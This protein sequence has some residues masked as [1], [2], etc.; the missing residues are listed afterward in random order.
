MKL[1]TQTFLVLVLLSMSISSYSQNYDKKNDI[2]KEI[3]INKK[4]LN[5]PL[6]L[7]RNAPKSNMSIKIDGDLLGTFEMPLAQDKEDYYGFIDLSQHLGKI[8]T[9]ELD[10]FSRDLQKFTLDD[11]IKGADNLYM[12]QY[13]PQLHFTSRRGWLNDPNGLI[14]YKGE[15]HMYYQHNPLSVYWGNLSW[16]HA[17]SKDLVHWEEQP[18]VLFPKS[19]TGTCYSGATFIDHNNQ[20]GLKTGE[21]DA[22]LAFY[23][24]TKIGLCFAYSNDRGQTMTEFEGNPVLT[25]EGARI[26]TPRP[27]WFE[28]TNRWIAPTFDFFTNEDG[29]KHRCVGFYSSKNLKD[30]RFESRVEQDKGIHELCGCVDFFQLPV[31]GNTAEKKWIMIFIDGSY[32]VGTFNGRT[33]YTLTGKPASTKDRIQSLVVSGNYYATMTWHNMPN[34]RRVQ[35]TWMKTSTKSFPGMPFNQ[36]M[37]LPSE[38]TL[39]LTKDGHRLHMNPIKELEKLRTKTHR[40]NNI[41]LD[42]TNNL[43]SVLNDELYEIEVEFLPRKKSITVLDLRGVKISYNALKEEISLNEIKTQL[44]PEDGKINLQ[45]FI[46]RTSIEVYA[47]GGKV[48]MPLINTMP[49]E[50][51]NYSILAAQGESKVK[52]LKV[53]ELSSIWF[54]KESIK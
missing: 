26:D 20:L 12:E 18:V 28:P 10:S 49:Q 24:R 37:T 23:L 44:K 21:E 29:K 39:H 42:K 16:G 14:Y 30:W 45:I 51:L 15:Y 1:K 31:D 27:F 35:I 22:L 32:I 50:N 5:I 11:V 9:V 3:I 53:H 8:L 41:V 47:N 46:D 19:E 54:V 6:L 2:E 33:F 52:S 40:W 4:Y 43:L 13:R 48:Y 25:H 38:L 7:D 17:V 36:Q 34:D